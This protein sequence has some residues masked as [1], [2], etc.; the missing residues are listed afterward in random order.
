MVNRKDAKAL[1][2]FAAEAQRN[3]LTAKA[4]GRNVFP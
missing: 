3:T 4:P 1:R 2:N